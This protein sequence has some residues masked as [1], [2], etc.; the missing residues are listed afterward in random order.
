MWLADPDRKNWK[1]CLGACPIRCVGQTNL[2]WHHPKDKTWWGPME[3]CKMQFPWTILLKSNKLSKKKTAIASTRHGG[4]NGLLGKVGLNIWDFETW[5][6]IPWTCVVL[7]WQHIDTTFLLARPSNQIA[8]SNLL[9]TSSSDPKWFEHLFLRKKS[10]CILQIGVPSR[11]F[12]KIKLN[13]AR[14]EGWNKQ[15]GLRTL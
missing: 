10:V 9:I 2:I 8:T 4:V 3:M 13:F 14:P 11:S 12:T 5:R 6:H 1:K 15:H 7:T